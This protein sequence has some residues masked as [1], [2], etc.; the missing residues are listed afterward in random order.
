LVMSTQP[1]RRPGVAPD[2]LVRNL[3]QRYQF[4][5]LAGGINTVSIM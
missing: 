5:G 1:T 3:L 2:R 4:A